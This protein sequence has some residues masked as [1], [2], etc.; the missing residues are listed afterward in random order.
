MSRDQRVKDNWALL[1]AQQEAEKRRQPLVVV[2]H[3][4]KSFLHAQSWHFSFLCQGLQ[5]VE[6]TLLAHNIPFILSR[7]TIED[8]LIPLL[9]SLNPSLVMN[10]FDPLRIKREWKTIVSRALLC[11]L[12][13]IDT[14]NIVP[15]WIASDKQEFSARTFRPKILRLLPEFLTDIPQI[16]FHPYSCS[17]Q[18]PPNEWPPHVALPPFSPLP[19]EKAGW[20][21]FLAFLSDGIHR[22]AQEK[23]IPLANATSRLSAYFHFGQLSPQRV[24]YEISQ[25]ETISPENKN[26]FLEELIVR[27]EL[28]D[29]FVFY[30][31]NYDNW[32][33]IPA[34]AQKSLNKHREDPRPFLYTLEEL[35]AAQT[36]EPLWN[37]CQKSMQKTGYL[38]GYL[39][40]YWAKKILEWSTTPEEALEKAIYLNDHYFLD[41]RDPNGYT[42]ILW[43]IGGLHDRPFSERPIIGQI[44]PMTASGCERKFSTQAFITW[45]ENL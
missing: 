26:T 11:P 21:T 5:E 2:F 33:G 17:I 23:N 37:A 41:G 24:A 45:A 14:H 12:L 27:R 18:L 39:R 36:H 22:Y 25:A 3:L 34:W 6:Q 7:G 1:Y 44:R 30:Q 31:K 15:C 16:S 19:G 9:K 43:S 8:N 10:D 42:G 20:E 29:N 28:S 35:E 40:M 13:E 4:Q 32:D 38:H